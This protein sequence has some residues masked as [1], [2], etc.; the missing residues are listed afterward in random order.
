MSTETA[1]QKQED[2]PL[3]ESKSKS[4]IC[5]TITWSTGYLC[6]SLVFNL[7]NSLIYSVLYP[8]ILK[9][10]AKKDEYMSAFS[11]INFVTTLASAVLLP[12]MGSIVDCL[13]WIKVSLVIIE[14]KN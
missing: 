5:K 13:K 9:N 4:H 11:V 12:L 14:K 1:T 8:E 10:I 7:L 2:N 3:I 6:F